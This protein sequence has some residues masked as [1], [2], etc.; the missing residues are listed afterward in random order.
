MKPPATTRVRQ[1]TYSMGALEVTP[2]TFKVVSKIVN[3]LKK[4]IKVVMNNEKDK[5]KI[6]AK[7]TKIKRPGSIQMI[8]CTDDYTVAE[9]RMTKKWTDKV[10]EHND[11]ESQILNTFEE[12]EVPKKTVCD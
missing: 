10:K 9:R 4:T 3:R 11:K 2:T 1:K 6:M 8:K 12:L 5:N 7:P